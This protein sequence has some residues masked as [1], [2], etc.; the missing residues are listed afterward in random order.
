MEDPSYYLD[1]PNSLKLSKEQIV[2]LVDIGPK[3]FASGASIP[4][5]A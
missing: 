5:Y 4:K 2:K 1:L 3:L